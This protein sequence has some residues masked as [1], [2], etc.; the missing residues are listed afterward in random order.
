MSVFVRGFK[1]NVTQIVTIH[2][3]RY[4]RVNMLQLHHRRRPPL[5]GTKCR[6]PENNSVQDE[7][8]APRSY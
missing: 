5:Y 1:K 2:S 3:L 7:L 4:T 6:N 8:S